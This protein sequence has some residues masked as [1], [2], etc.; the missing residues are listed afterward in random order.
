MRYCILHCSKVS[1]IPVK[2]PK[3]GR[4]RPKKRETEVRPQGTVDSEYVGVK[5]VEFLDKVSHQAGKKIDHRKE[6]DMPIELHFI[7]ATPIS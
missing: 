5:G 6:L 3:E 4:N 1:S 2:K 7:A